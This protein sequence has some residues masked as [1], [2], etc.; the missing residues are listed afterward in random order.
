MDGKPEGAPLVLPKDRQQITGE[1]NRSASQWTPIYPDVGWI[2]PQSQGGGR[3]PP[4]F[5]WRSNPKREQ[6]RVSYG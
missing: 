1:P 4:D 2:G 6:E 3:V 5:R